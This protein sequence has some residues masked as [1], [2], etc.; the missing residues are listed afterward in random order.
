MHC[1]A[2]CFKETKLQGHVFITDMNVAQIIPT[3]LLLVMYN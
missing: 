2:I 3:N 1:V